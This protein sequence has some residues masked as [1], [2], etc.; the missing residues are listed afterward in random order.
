MYPESVFVCV[1]VCESQSLLSVPQ[2]DSWTIHPALIEFTYTLG[3]SGEGKN[4]RGGEKKQNT[5]HAVICFPVSP[6][7]TAEIEAEY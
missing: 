7:D 2:T 1:C 3:R 6:P 4:N 5:L